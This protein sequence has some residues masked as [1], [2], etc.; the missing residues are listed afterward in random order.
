MNAKQDPDEDARQRLK[1]DYPSFSIIVTDRGR[2]WATRPTLVREDL[3]R[4]E[5]ATL[6]A[7]TPGELRELLEKA[8]R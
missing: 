7:D 8:D 2:W 3:S 4:T 5:G 1:D 6:E